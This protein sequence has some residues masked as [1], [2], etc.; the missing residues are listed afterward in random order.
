MQGVDVEGLA[1]E[2]KGR[3]AKRVILFGGA[4]DERLGAFK[5]GLARRGIM[6]IT[7]PAAAQR[8]IAAL[9]RQAAEDGQVPAADAERFSALVQDGLEHGVD[10]LVLLREGYAQLL[11]QCGVEAALLE[12]YEGV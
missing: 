12:V 4:D 1:A 3:G 2:L 7:P 8:W 5:M 6:V 11:E 9:A 10:A